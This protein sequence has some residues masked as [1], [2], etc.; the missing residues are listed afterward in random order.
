LTVRFATRQRFLTVARI[1]PQ[2]DALTLNLAYVRLASKAGGGH[3]L[4]S[5]SWG[6][7]RQFVLR[8]GVNTERLTAAVE[9]ATRRRHGAPR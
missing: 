2:V 3:D 8:S 4:A 9:R 7:S 5:T 1:S 6:A